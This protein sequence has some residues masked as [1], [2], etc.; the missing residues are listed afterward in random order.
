MESS[1]IRDTCAIRGQLRDATPE[2]TQGREGAKTQ[3]IEGRKRG[4]TGITGLPDGLRKSS[5][6]SCSSCLIALFHFRYHLGQSFFQIP[7]GPKTDPA[8]KDIRPTGGLMWTIEHT[9]LPTG[10]EGSTVG[11]SIVLTVQRLIHAVTDGIPVGR[12]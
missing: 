4:L 3:Q 12:E 9:E 1:F 5:C 11:K 2:L 7:L 10:R 6:P 8:G